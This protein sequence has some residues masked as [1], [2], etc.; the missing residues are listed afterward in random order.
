MDNLIAVD[1]T[2]CHSITS[3]MESKESI[4]KKRK[5]ANI[6]NDVE[7]SDAIVPS[8]KKKTFNGEREHATFVGLKPNCTISYPSATSIISCIL[9]SDHNLSS[10]IKVIFDGT[11][12]TLNGC[13]EGRRII[14]NQHSEHRIGD[15]ASIHFC[16]VPTLEEIFP[17]F[18]SYSMQNNIKR[19]IHVPVHLIDDGQYINYRDP[20]EPFYFT[21]TYVPHT[22]F[23][24]PISSNNMMM[25]TR[26]NN[27]IIKQRDDAEQRG[28]KNLI[29]AIGE[30]E[31]LDYQTHD[32]S[33]MY[34][35]SSPLLSP[36]ASSDSSFEA[37]YIPTGKCFFFLFIIFNIHINI[38]FLV[39]IYISMLYSL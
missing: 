4:D 16:Q 18:A 22:L 15:A 21:Y 6:E 1:A 20:T 13:M 34:S 33:N 26:E 37:S 9:V 31:N 29:D 2:R 23:N 12:S 35:P 36:S 7:N 5:H 39:I 32:E 25:Y 3:I 28:L 14:K 24:K 27:N 30:Q 19:D 11:K 10:Q 17:T 8:K 38:I